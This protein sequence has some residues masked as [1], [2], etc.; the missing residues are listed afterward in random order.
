MLQV[1]FEPTIPLFERAKTV[2]AS[3][4]EAAVIGSCD[5][6]NIKLEKKDSGSNVLNITS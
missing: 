3:G 5:I 2:H 6:T 1:G 4:R